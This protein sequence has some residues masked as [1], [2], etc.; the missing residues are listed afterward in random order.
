M[1][2]MHSQIVVEWNC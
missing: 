1:N 2:N